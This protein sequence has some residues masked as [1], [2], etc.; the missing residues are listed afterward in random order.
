LQIALAVNL[1]NNE[2]NSNTVR[3]TNHSKTKIK[4]WENE[5]VTDFQDNIDEEKLHAFEQ[6]LSRWQDEISV[7]DQ[8]IRDSLLENIDSILT[9]SAKKTFGTFNCKNIDSKINKN[10][11]GQNKKP[12][13][14]QDCKIAR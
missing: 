1:S 8:A 10:K 12:W 13:F 3:R 5:K 9:D 7:T 14:D 2:S 6:K 4:S 11:N